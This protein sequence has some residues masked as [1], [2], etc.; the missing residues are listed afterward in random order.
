M[1]I[2]FLGSSHGVPEKRRNCSCVKFT[3]GENIYF[4]DMG[5]DPMGHIRDHEIPLE[6]IKGVFISHFHGDHMNGL[7]PFVDIINWYFKSAA[8]EIRLPN[9]DVIDGVKAW[10][11]MVEGGAE[12]REGIH[13]DIIRP[14]VIFD[15]GVLRVTAFPTKHC[16]DS[17][18]FLLEAE[19]KRV[20]YTGDM[21]SPPVD[22]VQ[23]EADKGL[24][25]LICEGAH[26]SAMEYVSRV[27]G[28]AIQKLVW[29]HHNTWNNIN[30]F[31]M[32]EEIAPIVAEMSYDGMEFEV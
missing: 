5:T 3:V 18:S 8:P 9:Q 17:F 19:G 28:R 20:L 32:R 6:A 21:A 26:F 1:K 31:Q 16:K 4:V 22:F 14:G 30:F 23:E 11:T 15:D 13:F 27:K 2:T 10:C 24:N 25:L 7:I 12:V 29:T